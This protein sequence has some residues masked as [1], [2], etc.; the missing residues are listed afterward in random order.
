VR[1]IHDRLQ[2]EVDALPAELVQA[3]AKAE[4]DKAREAATREV[5]SIDAAMP[6]PA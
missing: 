1:S 6:S 2:A 3:L 5:P 4:E